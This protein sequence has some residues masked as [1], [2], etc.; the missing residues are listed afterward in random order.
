MAQALII[1][2]SGTA[3]LGVLYFIDQLINTIKVPTHTVNPFPETPSET[4]AT[5]VGEASVMASMSPVVETEIAAV[6][7][8]TGEAVA[9]VW[10]SSAEH[11]TKI[12]EAAL[13]ALSHH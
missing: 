7:A 2:A 10:E 6:A 12:G 4:I 9:G 5:I 8:E 3:L 13:H 1:A 11:L